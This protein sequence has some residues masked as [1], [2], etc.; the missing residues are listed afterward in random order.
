MLKKGPVFEEAIKHTI[1]REPLVEEI[2]RLITPAGESRLYPVII[3]EH[4]TG[5]RSLIELAVNGMKE[6]KGVAYA[7]MDDTETDAAQ[8]MQEAL[9]WSP[10]QLL[11]SDKRNYS[12]SLLVLLKTNRFAA[13]SMHDVLRL[14]SNLAIKYK[15]EYKRVPV[16]IIDNAN[17]LAQKQEPVLDQLQ[18]YA[19]S[20]ADR[21]VV[22]VV[23]VSSEGRVPRRM[24][25]KSIMFMLIVMC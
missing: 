7:D 9:G 17:K 24:M 5:K 3:G 2:R 19:K 16:L 8:R 18:D 4:G 13:A 6:P 11:D 14:F 1:P 10:D 20:A 23:F 25:G 15:Q 21:G 12:S 22:T